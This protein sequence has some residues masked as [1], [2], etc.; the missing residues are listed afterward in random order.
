MAI[1]FYSIKF[2]FNKIQFHIIKIQFNIIIEIKCTEMN[3]SKIGILKKALI[4]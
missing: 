2:Q 1:N 4:N 3:R